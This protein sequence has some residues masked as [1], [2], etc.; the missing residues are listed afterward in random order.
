MDANFLKKGEDFDKLPETWIIFI[1]VNDVMGKGLL[2]PIERRLL[3]TGER[4][5]GAGLW[6]TEHHV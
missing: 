5:L 3:E 6:G 2:Y 1:T 4:Q